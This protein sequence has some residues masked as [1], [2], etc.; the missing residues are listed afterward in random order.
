M[1]AVGSLLAHCSLTGT[2]LW[3]WL[4]ACSLFAYC[5][6]TVGSPLAHCLLA[7]AGLWCWL[8]NCSPFAPCLLA[9][10]SP[11]AHCSLAGKMLLLKVTEPKRRKEIKLW[12]K[13]KTNTEIPKIVHDASLLPNLSNF[14]NNSSGQDINR[15]IQCI[16]SDERLPDAVDPWLSSHQCG[17]LHSHSPPLQCGQL[18]VSRRHP[19]NPDGNNSSSSRFLGCRLDSEDSPVPQGVDLA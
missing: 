5:L 3:C 17:P 8:T 2:G 10:D 14:V 6:L 13:K 18:S 15:G 7:G 11:F 4:T 19:R 1:L 12:T 9:I 16:D